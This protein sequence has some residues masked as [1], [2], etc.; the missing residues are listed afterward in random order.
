MVIFLTKVTLELLESVQEKQTGTKEN[1][2]TFTE[3]TLILQLY[4]LWTLI[5]WA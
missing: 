5:I 4:K 1:K 3:G 2:Q